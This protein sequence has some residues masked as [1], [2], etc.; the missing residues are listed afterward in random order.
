MKSF[1]VNMKYKK[2][3]KPGEPTGAYVYEE[4]TEAGEQVPFGYFKIGTLYIRKEAAPERPEFIIV[5]TTPL[6]KVA[7][8]KSGTGTG[9]PTRRKAPVATEA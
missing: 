2:E 7:A 4:C 9:A 6:V 3:T 1:T 5:T 8:G